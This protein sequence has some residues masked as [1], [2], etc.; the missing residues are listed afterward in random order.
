VRLSESGIRSRATVVRL[1][2][3][4]ADAIL[5][6]EHLMRAADAAAALYALRGLENPGEEDRRS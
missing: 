5:I 4:G 6:G 1:E 2:Q 3:A